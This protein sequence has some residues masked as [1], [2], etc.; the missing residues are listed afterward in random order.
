[1]E[2]V[3]WASW[4]LMKEWQRGTK[5]SHFENDLREKAPCS[6]W[7]ITV[8]I[9]RSFLEKHRQ[10]FKRFSWHRPSKASA[11]ACGRGFSLDAEGIFTLPISIR[12]FWD[13]ED[14][15]RVKKTPWIIPVARNTRNAKRMREMKDPTLGRWKTDQNEVNAI[16]LFWIL[17]CR[18]WEDFKKWIDLNQKDG[19]LL[20]LLRRLFN[21]K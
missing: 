13:V 6:M 19:V 8:K 16:L 15:E 18:G 14:K 12:K 11:S 7:R 1:M 10:R 4:V 3:W 20:R 5:R 9:E 2:D 17:S 21:T